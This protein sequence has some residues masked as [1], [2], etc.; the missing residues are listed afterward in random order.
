[1]ELILT[2]KCFV[3]GLFL[4]I[5]SVKLEFMYIVQLT[6]HESIGAEA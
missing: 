1:M 5:V 6:F 3:L 4:L 2:E